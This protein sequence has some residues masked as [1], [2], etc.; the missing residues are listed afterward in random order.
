MIDEDFDNGNWMAEL[1]RQRKL[2]DPNYKTDLEIC[3]ELR[4]QGRK[5]Q[6]TKR[7]QMANLLNA[8]LD[9]TAYLTQRGIDLPEGT[10]VAIKRW[11][12]ERAGFEGIKTIAYYDRSLSRAVRDFYGGE[13]DAGSS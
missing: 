2:K 6:R 13:I 7:S 9:A 1:Q 5:R 12:I 8:I 10:A 11:Q 4:A 3:Q